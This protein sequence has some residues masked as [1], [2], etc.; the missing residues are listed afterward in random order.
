MICIDVI[1]DQRGR[2]YQ[3]KG[4]MIGHACMHIIEN[5]MEVGSI[6]ERTCMR[7]DEQ[8]WAQRTEHEG[9]IAVKPTYQ[10]GQSGGSPREVGEMAEG[11]LGPGG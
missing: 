6:R 1:R 9:I 7:M 4:K 11:R 5:G 10:E 3:S 8:R 2:Q